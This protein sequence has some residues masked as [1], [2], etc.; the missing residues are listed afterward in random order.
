MAENEYDRAR[1][2]TERHIG[3]LAGVSSQASEAAAVMASAKAISWAI[4]TLAE[5]LRPQ[6]A[7]VNV[8][9]TPEAVEALKVR[10]G[11]NREPN[12]R[13]NPWPVTDVSG[14]ISVEGER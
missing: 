5:A 12:P 6:P 7:Q 9:V 13:G 8:D 1:E 2:A 10:I 11:E 3:G 4:L 14:S